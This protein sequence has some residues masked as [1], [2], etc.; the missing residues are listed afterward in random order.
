MSDLQNGTL[1][2]HNTLGLG[3]IVAVEPGAVHVFFPASDKRFAAKLRLPAARPLLRT[4]GFEPDGW[5][6]GLSAFSLDEATGRYA[7]SATWMTHDQALAQFKE[8]HPGGFKAL[9]AAVGVKGKEAR[10]A[11]WRAARAAWEKHLGNGE[12]ARLVSEGEV[13]LLVKKALEVEKALAPL[14]PPADEGAIAAALAD[15]AL[16]RPFFVALTELLSVPTP[17]KARFEKLFSAARGLPVEPAQQ[18]LV[19]TIFPFIA[20]PTR[21][22]LM[23]PRTTCLAADRLGCDVR[24]QPSPIWATY[25]ALRDLQTKLLERL[26][27]EGAED[28]ADIEAFLHVVAVGRRSTAAAKVARKPAAEGKAKAARS[29]A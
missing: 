7:L 11:R 15:E 27:P 5:L 25:S 20:E 16:A 9:A 2:K 29:K 21:H 10:P 4:E 6:A 23:R 1:V 8:L 26:A 14:H 13:E 22:V 28:F 24:F 19:A 12:A 3:K 18:W 17:G